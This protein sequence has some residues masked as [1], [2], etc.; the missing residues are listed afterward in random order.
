MAYFDPLYTRID[1]FTALRDELPGLDQ[2]DGLIGAAVAVSMHELDDADV[3][4]VQ[5]KLDDL[6]EQVQDR[7][8][9]NNPRAIVAH[10]HQVLFEEARFRGNIGNYADSANS[11]LPRVLHSR[12][13]LPITLALVYKAV[14]ERLGVPV[15]GINAPG[16]FLVSLPA[17]AVGNIVDPRSPALIAPFFS[18]ALLTREEA[19]DRVIQATGTDLLLDEACDLLPV[20]THKQW[21]IRLVRNLYQGFDQRGQR[22]DANAMA[23]MMR[24][25][26]AEARD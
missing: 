22:D 11:Y 4:E 24:L 3:I 25:I 5:T 15:F 19:M 23:E 13:G 9:S 12:L 14:L 20:A 26:E 18:G 8:I 10:A 17:S 16:H 6:A 1:A 21:L 7:V 2:T